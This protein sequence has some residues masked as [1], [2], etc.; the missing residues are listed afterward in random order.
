MFSGRSSNGRKVVSTR[1]DH[2]FALARTVS[3]RVLQLPQVHRERYGTVSL[4][5][6]GFREITPVSKTG[7]LAGSI[8]LI[9]AVAIANGPSGLASLLS[10]KQI[11]AAIGPLVAA[12]CW[13][14]SFI[15]EIAKERRQSASR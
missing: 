1:T 9:A 10:W 2:F 7:L 12:V 13:M 3:G 6:V 4:W 8:A 15:V 14:L 5:A 11:L